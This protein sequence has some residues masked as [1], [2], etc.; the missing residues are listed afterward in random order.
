MALALCLGHFL[1]FVALIHAV[2]KRLPICVFVM[3]TCMHFVSACARA[4]ACAS[5][6]EP[7]AVLMRFNELID[8]WLRNIHGN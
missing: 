8:R 3:C 6:S 4:R 7:W 1:Q 2:I 5:A